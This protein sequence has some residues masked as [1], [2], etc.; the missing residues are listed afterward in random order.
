M[1]HG[2]DFGV[3]QRRADTRNRTGDA[4]GFRQSTRRRSTIVH[5]NR[6][7]FR[8]RRSTPRCSCIARLPMQAR[9]RRRRGKMK[10]LS[11]QF[12]PPD[13]LPTHSFASENALAKVRPILPPINSRD[14]QRELNAFGGMEAP[15]ETTGIFI[16]LRNRRLEMN[17]VALAGTKCRDHLRGRTGIDNFDLPPVDAVVM[18]GVAQHGERLRPMVGEQCL[19]FQVFPGKVLRRGRKG[20]SRR[21]D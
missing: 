7:E 20:R 5:T 14:A 15:T 18:H 4:A 10:P 12:L 13:V 11:R 3:K 8:Y 19:S 17:K 6:A 21:A 2:N 16:Q 1:L 9:I